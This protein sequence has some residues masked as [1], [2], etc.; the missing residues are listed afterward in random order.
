MMRR[1][2]YFAAGL[3]AGLC[4]QTGVAQERGIVSLNHVSLAV[5]NFDEAA[6]FYTSVMGFP[7][8]FAFR[9]ANGPYLSYFQ[10][11]RN[12][13][14]ELM[15]STPERPPGFVHFGL[16]VGNV[17]SVVSRLRAQGVQVGN[18]SVSPR[19]KSRVATATTPQGTRFELLEF[20]PES[21]HRKVIEGWRK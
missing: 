1:V 16:E 13:F 7:E 12:T 15:P 4:L 21:L 10:I 14:I 9:D 19:T 5:E 2:G 3:F 11:N 17:D 8:A 18:A 20:G 6:K